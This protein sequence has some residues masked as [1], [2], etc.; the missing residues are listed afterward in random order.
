MEKVLSKPSALLSKWHQLPSTRSSSPG[1]QTLG[2]VQVAQWHSD[3]WGLEGECF[4][5][6]R[7]GRPAMA[8]GFCPLRLQSQP[9][10]AMACTHTSCSIGKGH[11]ALLHW[12][13]I[14]WWGWTGTWRTSDRWKKMYASW[15]DRQRCS[16]P[17]VCLGFSLVEECSRYSTTFHQHPGRDCLIQQAVGI[18]SKLLVAVVPPRPCPNLLSTCL[19]RQVSPQRPSTDLSPGHTQPPGCFPYLVCLF[20]SVYY[21]LIPELTYVH[22]KKRKKEKISEHAEKWKEQN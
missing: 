19:V 14:Q 1:C 16:Q 7:W 21:F 20:L 13:Q 8:V 22:D 10:R 12:E 18:A 3:T 9:C 2:L 6:K 17:K 15:P 5:Q 4:T 11:P